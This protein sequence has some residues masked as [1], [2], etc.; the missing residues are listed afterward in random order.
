MCKSPNQQ[1]DG[2]FPYFFIRLQS[3]VNVPYRIFRRFR[4]TRNTQHSYM[5]QKWGYAITQNQSRI[6]EDVDHFFV[7]R[8]DVDLR[9]FASESSSSAIKLASPYSLATSSGDA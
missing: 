5:I 6:L 4:Y 1:S 9:I 3:V 2:N 7:K 8:T